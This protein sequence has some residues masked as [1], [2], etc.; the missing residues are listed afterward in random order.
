MLALISSEPVA[1]V[2]RFLFTC[3][4]ELATTWAWVEVSSELAVISWLARP[5]VSSVDGYDVFRGSLTAE[6]RNVPEG[7]RMIAP[8]LM[9][10][11]GAL[12]LVVVL[13]FGALALRRRTPR[14]QSW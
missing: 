7:Y 8:E 4:L 13:I 12:A 5:Q 1:T 10:V 11:L 9:I 14:R 6:V 2:C 3:S